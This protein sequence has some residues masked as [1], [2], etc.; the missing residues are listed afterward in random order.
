MQRVNRVVREKKLPQ[1][2]KIPVWGGRGR[3]VASQSDIVTVGWELR[4]ECQVERV[5][6]TC[7]G[8]QARYV[9]ESIVAKV[10]L[11]D[12]RHDTCHINVRQCIVS[13]RR[14]LKSKTA[15]QALQQT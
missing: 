15:L 8:L 9:Y 14:R 10:E 12:T 2:W 4:V 13:Q 1:G 7:Y 6:K 11:G 5:L 3:A